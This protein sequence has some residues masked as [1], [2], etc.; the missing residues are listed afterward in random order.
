[1]RLS[2]L[3]SLITRMVFQSLGVEKYLDSH[4]ESLNHSIRVMRYEAPMTRE[5]QRGS[6]SHC[7]KSFLTI[8]QQN[9]VNALE[10]QTKDGKWIQV[11][12][13]ASTFIVMV[14]ESFL[15]SVFPFSHAKA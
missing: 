11:A 13:S 4:A 12:P 1:M 7:D 10:V 3:E 15:V 8:L 6:S 14:G 9:H 2:E 5:P